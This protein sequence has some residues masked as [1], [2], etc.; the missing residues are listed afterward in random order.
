M[1]VLDQKTKGGDAVINKAK[2]R[3]WVE[4]NKVDLTPPV[5][6]EGFVEMTIEDDEEEEEE[7]EEDEDEGDGN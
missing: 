1:Q 4:S 7:E 2:V 3:A 5:D 6:K